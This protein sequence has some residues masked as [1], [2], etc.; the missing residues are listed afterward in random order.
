MLVFTDIKVS[1]EKL[2]TTKTIKILEVSQA[3]TVKSMITG[4]NK[5][6]PITQDRSVA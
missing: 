4:K 2:E 1:N 6:L 5:T 3:E